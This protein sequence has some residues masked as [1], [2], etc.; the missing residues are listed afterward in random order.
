MTAISWKNAV[1]GDWN[2]ASDWSTNTLPG[3]SDAVTISAFGPYIVTISSADLANSLTFNASEAALFENAGSLTMAGA[4]TVDSGFVS[5]NKAN[6]IG[7]VSIAGGALAFGNGAALGA[8]A[9][10]LSGGELLATANE[11]VTNELDFTG[12][13]TIAAARGTTLTENASS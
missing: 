11:T 10:S 3:L 8:G 7:S 1:S 13:S 4:L 12:T 6:T 2:N 5:L 9:V